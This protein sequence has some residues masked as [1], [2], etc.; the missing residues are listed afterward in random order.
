MRRLHLDRRSLL[1]GLVG[2]GLIPRR[3]AAGN[4]PWRWAVDYS[5]RTDPAIARGYD[6]LVLEPD[7]PRPITPLRGPGSQLLGYLSLG[8]VEK[9]RDFIGLLRREGALKT[10]NQNWPDARMVDLRHPAWT[11]LVLD[12]LIPDI[13]SKGYD[14][15]FFDTLD[16]AEALER[17]DPAGCAGMVDAAAELVRSIRQ[18]FPRSVLMMNRGYALLPRVASHVDLVLGEA[19][20]SRWNF[21]IK[22]YEFTPQADWSWQA[23]RLIAAREANPALRLATLDYWDPADRET[24][25]NLYDRERQAGFCP[26]VATLALDRIHPEPRS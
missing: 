19:M 21:A 9:G 7:H 26:Y 20:A 23:E 22:Q 13:L 18:R 11:R 8:E 15:I 17:K 5:A 24:I 16:N 6:L 4:A 25:A 14:G 1:A 2:I 10:A 3:L 12:R